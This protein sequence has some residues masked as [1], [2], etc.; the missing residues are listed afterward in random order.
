MGQPGVSI[1]D[2]CRERE[3]FDDFLQTRRDSSGDLFFLAGY[4][5]FDLLRACPQ[6]DLHRLVPPAVAQLRRLDAE[7]G[8]DYWGTLGAYVKSGLNAAKAAK[9]LYIHPNTML[10]RLKRAQELLGYDLSDP[11]TLFLLLF[12]YR[13]EAYMPQDSGA[14]V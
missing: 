2:A 1:G 14:Q 6:A 4:P 10:E 7:N 12:T 9:M 13:M 5:E 8:T 3:L 11:D